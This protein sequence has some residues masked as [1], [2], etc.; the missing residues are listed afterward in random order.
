MQNPNETDG[1]FFKRINYKHREEGESGHTDDIPWELGVRARSRGTVQ[2]DK[3]NCIASELATCGHI[4][5]Y[6][7][8]GWWKERKEK[9][10]NAKLSFSL[11]VSVKTEDIDLDLYNPIE[12][13]ITQEVTS[14]VQEVTIST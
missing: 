13:K 3:W 10:K 5:V 9:R 6:P 14:E 1:E 11:I 4:I 2:S 7:V 8:N 12:E